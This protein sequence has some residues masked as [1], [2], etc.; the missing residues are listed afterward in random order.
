GLEP[1]QVLPEFR[2]VAAMSRHGDLWVPTYGGGTIRTEF[3][4]LT[5]IAMRYFPEVEYPYFRLTATALP[6]LPSVLAAHGYRTVAMHP[7]E[8]EFWNR[9]SALSHLGFD[10]FDAGEQ[11]GDAPLSGWYV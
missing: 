4:V 7:H 1:D 3:E 10:E 5:G 6:S 2:R 9:A 8:R 11:F